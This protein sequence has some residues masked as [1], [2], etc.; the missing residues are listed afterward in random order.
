M[1]VC[2]NVNTYMDAP[3]VKCTHVTSSL[4]LQRAVEMS[5]TYIVHTL[6]CRKFFAAHVVCVC[7]P[8]CMQVF[9]KFKLSRTISKH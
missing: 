9:L 1:Y 6:A 7:V 5:S 2:N 8:L 4:N 3:R